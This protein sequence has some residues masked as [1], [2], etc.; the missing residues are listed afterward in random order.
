MTEI[1]QKLTDKVQVEGP[2]PLSSGPGSMYLVGFMP[3]ICYQASDIGV[4][5]GAL[6]QMKQIAVESAMRILDWDGDPEDKIKFGDAGLVTPIGKVKTFLQEI[7]N[8]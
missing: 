6:P 8:S 4:D 7:L 1:E 2:I 3:Y 5:A